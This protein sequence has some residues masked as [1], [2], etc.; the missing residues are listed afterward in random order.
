MKQLFDLF[1]IQIY[2]P[3]F[4]KKLSFIR[5]EASSTAS[6]PKNIG[7]RKQLER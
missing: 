4:E 7:R 5:T 6:P 2:F 3:P 1:C